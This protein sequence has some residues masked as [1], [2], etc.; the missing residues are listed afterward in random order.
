MQRDLLYTHGYITATFGALWASPYLTRLLQ[1]DESLFQLH[2]TPETEAFIIN[3]A[4]QHS[5]PSTYN[6]N[7]PASPIDYKVREQRG[8]GSVVPQSYLGSGTPDDAQ[9]YNNVSLKMPIFFIHSDRK[10]LGLRLE[11]AAMGDCRGLLDGHATA[12]VGDSLAT[13]IR[14]KVSVSQVAHRGPIVQTA[15]TSSGLATTNGQARL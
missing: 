3:P 7:R 11:E 10:T 9:H 12:P 1:F 14:V 2:F 6:R 13:S 5:Q 4:F 8:Y 15:F